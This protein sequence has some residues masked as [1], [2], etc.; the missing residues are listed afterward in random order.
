[1]CP[2]DGAVD[3]LQGIGITAAISQGLQQHIPQARRGP[4]PI[5]SVDRVP[6]AQ[7]RRQIAP[8]DARACHPEYPIQHPAV[9][10]GRTPAKG[11]GLHHEGLEE[12]PFL[13]R[14]QTP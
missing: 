11:T 6:V 14:Q 7:L 8:R 2:D 5:L 3:H 1:M 13:V 10:A 12:S 9:T 4:A